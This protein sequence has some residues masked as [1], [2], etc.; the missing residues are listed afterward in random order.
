M[1]HEQNLY[2]LYKLVILT[3]FEVL[4]QIFYSNLVS[5]SQYQLNQILDVIILIFFEIVN[6]YLHYY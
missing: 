2:F 6:R 1:H 5:A 3:K 4:W